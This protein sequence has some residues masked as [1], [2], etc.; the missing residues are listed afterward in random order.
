MFMICGPQSPF[1]NIPVVIDNAV[2]WI[3]RRHRAPRAVAELRHLEATP[4]AVAGVDRTMATILHATV[5][6]RGRNSWFLGANVPESRTVLFYFGGA[7]RTISEG[8]C[9]A[10]ITSCGQDPV[11]S[12]RIVVHGITS[13]PAGST[14]PASRA[15]I[16]EL[17][18]W[19]RPTSSRITATPKRTW[20]G[21]VAPAI[22]MCI[23]PRW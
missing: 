20:P 12:G 19:P 6:P 11:S 10:G 17:M 5:V 7:N 13:T 22:K 2:R 15:P 3:G 21:A 16:A 14:S 1:A 9:I 18:R 4:D 8:D 23:R